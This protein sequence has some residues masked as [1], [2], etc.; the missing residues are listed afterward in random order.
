MDEKRIIRVLVSVIVIMA[1]LMAYFVIIKP[2]IDKAATNNQIEGYNI[3]ITSLLS[4]LEQQGYVQMTIG[5]QTL[6]L[7]PYNPQN[8]TR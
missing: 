1:L 8:T 3:A 7:V 4:Q 6:V 5:N 2:Q